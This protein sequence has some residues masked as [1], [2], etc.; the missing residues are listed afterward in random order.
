[1]NLQGVTD[2]IVFFDKECL[3][4]RNAGPSVTNVAGDGCSVLVM[5]KKAVV[6]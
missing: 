5:W 2:C 6:R 1:M 3:Q 4:N